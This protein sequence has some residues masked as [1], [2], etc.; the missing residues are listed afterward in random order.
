[1]AGGLFCSRYFLN[2]GAGLPARCQGAALASRA[3]AA[4]PPSP[5]LAAPSRASSAR[6]GKGRGRTWGADRAVWALGPT[7]FH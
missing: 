3:Q 6:P 2:G 7:Q 1:M 5:G 4:L